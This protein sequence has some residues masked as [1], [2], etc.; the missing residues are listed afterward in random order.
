MRPVNSTPL[1]APLVLMPAR[2]SR[3]MARPLSSCSTS[4]LSRPPLRSADHQQDR[5]RSVGSGS[6]VVRI[7]S[8]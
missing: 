7:Q 3:G 5:G 4:H 8:I 1:N 2:F 6:R